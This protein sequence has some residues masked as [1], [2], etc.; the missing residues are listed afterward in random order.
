MT[1]YYVDPDGVYLGGFSMP[2]SSGKEPKHPK[3]P[4]GAIE[5]PTPPG[6]ARQL[7]ANAAWGEAPPRAPSPR[8]EFRSRVQVA[9]SLDDIQAA[10]LSGYL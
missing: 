3:V 2:K 5:V 7:W 4:T 10:L 8:D 6:D 1:K 9:A